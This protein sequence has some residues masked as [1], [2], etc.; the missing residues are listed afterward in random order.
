MPTD[1]STYVW[2]GQL[3]G[4]TAPEGH[5]RFV[6]ESSTN[7]EMIESRTAEVYTQITEARNEGGQVFLIDAGGLAIAAS[8]ISALR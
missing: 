8:E 6:V 1:E 7:G 3:N 4:S 5:Y 2:D